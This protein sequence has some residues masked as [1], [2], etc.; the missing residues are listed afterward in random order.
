MDGRIVGAAEA[1]CCRDET[2]WAKRADY[3]L[4]SMAQTRATSKALRLPLGFVMA[5]AGFEATPEEEIPEEERQTAPR[6]AQRAPATN[7]DLTAETQ[8]AVAAAYKEVQAG[9]GAGFTPSVRK[10]MGE[11]WP[12]AFTPQA[13][14]ITALTEAEGLEVLA[15]LEKEMPAV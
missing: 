13:N 8:S 3:A 14:R 15:F 11:R 4:R 12:A 6:P 10:T 5:M 2:T 7:T 1:Q 9:R